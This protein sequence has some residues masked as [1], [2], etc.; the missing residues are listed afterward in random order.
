MSNK[1]L[2]VVIVSTMLLLATAVIATP[3]KIANA[4]Q[5]LST[6]TNQSDINVDQQIS[7]L[8]SKFPLL[9]SSQGTEVK[10]IIQKI[11]GLDK[12][13]ALKTLAAFHILR[14]LQEYKEFAG[15]TNS[16]SG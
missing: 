4:Q 6:S 1:K 2:N 10:D 7:D 12:Q 5:Q 9:S 11:Q 13:Q 15:S 8:K 14:N 3:M 16:S